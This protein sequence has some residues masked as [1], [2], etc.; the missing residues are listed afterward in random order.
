MLMQF[1]NSDARVN[2]VPNGGNGAPA[3]R[4]PCRMNY[5]ESIQMARVG[6]NYRFG[7]AQPDD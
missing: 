4:S 6:L 3:H 7:Y 1:Q 5:S 2:E